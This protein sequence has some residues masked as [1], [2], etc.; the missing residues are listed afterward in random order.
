MVPTPSLPILPPLSAP[1]LPTPTPTR[2]NEKKDQRERKKGEK[3]I[4]RS[5]AE[6]VLGRPASPYGI[7]PWKQ[8]WAFTLKIKG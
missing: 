2:Q 7:Q 3:E 8:T 4:Q 5:P 1:Q 6:C